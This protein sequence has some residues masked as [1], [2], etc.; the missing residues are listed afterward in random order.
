MWIIPGLA[1]FGRV[2]RCQVGGGRPLDQDG[3]RAEVARLFAERLDHA[4]PLWPERRAPAGR[5]AT[6]GVG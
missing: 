5:A 4:R 3:L 1:T 2:R 6:F